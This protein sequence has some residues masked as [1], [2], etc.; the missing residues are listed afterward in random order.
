IKI[1]WQ[2]AAADNK[3]P[4]NEIVVVNGKKSTAKI[5]VS[6]GTYSATVPVGDGLNRVAVELNNRWGSVS[7]Q[8]IEVRYVRP[9]RIT[10]WR[11]PAKAMTSVVELVAEVDSALP[12]RRDSVRAEVNGNSIV[13]YDVLRPEQ[14]SPRTW[15]VRL[16]NVLLGRK[17]ENVVTLSVANEEDRSESSSWRVEYDP[18]SPPEVSIIEPGRDGAT[19]MAEVSVRIRVKSATPLQEVTLVRE[20]GEKWSR[21]LDPERFTKEG[22]RYLSAA[23]QVPLEE[24]ANVIRAEAANK[25]GAHQDTRKISY[26]P[27]PV[28]LE[29]TELVARGEKGRTP[30]RR[31]GELVVTEPVPGRV[32]L[33]GRVVWA[34]ADDERLGK[35]ATVRVFV[36]GFQQV[37]ADLA[38]AERGSRVR[39]FERDIILNRDKGNRIEVALADLPG[40]SGVP[41]RC[42]VDC[43]RPVRGQR[44]H[45]LVVS[46]QEVDPAK[47]EKEFLEAF[48]ARAGTPGV[49]QAP[50]FDRVIVYGP[51]VGDNAH[52][53]YVNDQ[54]VRIHQEIKGNAR[55]PGAGNDVVV[56]YFK[57]GEAFT[58]EGN[59]LFV[60]TGRRSR[61][62]VVDFKRLVDLFA[63]T[64]GAQVLLFDVDREPKMGADTRRDSKD[65]IERWEDF[66]RDVRNHVAVLRYAWLGGPRSERDP[67][68]LRALQA[69]LPQAS[70]LLDV[71]NQLRTSAAS[72]A[73]KLLY[74]PRVPEELQNLRV[75][76]RP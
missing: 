10:K 67:M 7:R 31:G 64:P 70:L 38:P 69:A 15:R 2:L 17:G 9:P 43:S 39:T 12:L 24:G 23:V 6:D 14:D 61:A 75:G 5:E 45:L 52:Y 22:D 4:F 27:P 46:A 25:G 63:D 35:P 72:G 62:K 37:P 71:T 41:T 48:R 54:L 57:G 30:V 8:E 1:T 21:S 33:R 40:L 44:L 3:H 34:R 18:P 29:I 60:A 56:F 65:Q 16:K 42:T 58:A 76:A 66:H 13:N 68:L 28:L 20:G 47:L 73:E 19:Q 32:K 26:L 36:N 51:L 74:H 53:A 50:S 59:H 55:S 49:L 11:G